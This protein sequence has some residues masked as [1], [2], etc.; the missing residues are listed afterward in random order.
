VAAAS[1]AREMFQIA[2]LSDH[3]DIRVLPE[4]PPQGGREGL[5]MH[6][7]L[8]VVDNG[9]SLWW[10]NSIGFF[11]GDDMVF[12]AGVGFVHDGCEGRGF[13]T[14]CGPVTRTNPSAAWR[15][16]ELPSAS[17]VPRKS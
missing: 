1:M 2:H 9:F 16:V 7:H 12:A 11:N 10:T 5:G 17:R 3:D 8:S 6:P 4:W 13:A 14:A 15:G